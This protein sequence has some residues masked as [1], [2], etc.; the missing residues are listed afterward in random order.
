[1]SPPAI[2]YFSIVASLVLFTHI[3]RWY[4]M[5]PLRRVPLEGALTPLLLFQ[6]FRYIGLA[7]LVPGVVSPDL[8]AGFARPAAYGD[9][10]A[11][12]LAY[13]ALLA[14]RYRWR[15]A[16]PLV[17]LFNVVGFLDL[18]NAFI[19]AARHGAEPAQLGAMYFIP[20]LRVPS[21]YVVHYMIFAL[22]LRRSPQPFQGVP[23]P[24]Q[25]V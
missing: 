24:G 10:L 22:L 8:P 4:V 16:I 23:E 17:W 1:M 18:V 2:F 19:Q 6:C 5:P 11:C 13:L 21:L 20:T 25:E 7:F 14:M 3:A 15:L 12:V 9:L